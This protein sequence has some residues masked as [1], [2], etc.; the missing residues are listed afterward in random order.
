MMGLL[1][2]YSPSSPPNKTVGKGKN[3]ILSAS[4]HWITS[5]SFSHSIW[6]LSRKDSSGI[7]S[8]VISCFLSPE[9]GA[10]VAGQFN[11]SEKR[12]E[13]PGMPIT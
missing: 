13:S 6:P 9:D 8:V 11:G 2:G 7:A 5:T 4:K 1:L 3:S 10:H 12:S